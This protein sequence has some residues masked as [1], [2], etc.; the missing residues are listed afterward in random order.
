MAD[1]QHLAQ[2]CGGVAAFNQWRAQNP[3]ITPDLTGADLTKLASPG[4]P[5]CDPRQGCLNLGGVNLKGA[6]LNQACLR[7]AKLSG[8]ELD[9][10]FLMGADLGQTVLVGASFHRA[11][12]G[13]ADLRGAKLSLLA[14]TGDRSDSWEDQHGW[15]SAH[16]VGF[17]EAHLEGADLRGADLREA[18]FSQAVLV[19]ADLRRADL[20]SVNL[21][22]ANVTGVRFTRDT[23]QRAYFGMRV[24]TCY[25]SQTFKSHAEGQIFV[26]EYRRSRPLLFW[27]WRITSDCGTSL[28]LWALWSTVLGVGFGLLYYLL[29]PDYFQLSKLPFSLVTMVYYSGVTFTTLG[30][31]DITPTNEVSAFLVLLEVILGYVMLGGLISILA[32]RLAKRG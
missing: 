16:G 3:G 24:A 32:R 17:Q 15:A 10:A 22:Q 25:G 5:L 2:L 11:H 18:D 21:E 12:L 7:G 8:A 23:R 31:G 1:Q 28:G 27:L 29:G 13:G 9:D 14:F 19:G 20:R 30:F 26:E 6:L 4:G